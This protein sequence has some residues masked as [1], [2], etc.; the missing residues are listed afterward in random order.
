MDTDN[1][2]VQS[3]LE[4]IRRDNHSWVNGDSSGYE[5]GDESSSIMGAFGGSA[6]GASAATPGQRRAVT[7]FIEGSGTVEL[8]NCGVSDDVVWLA[9][10]ERNTVRF[11]KVDGPRRWD[12]R[13]TEVFRRDGAE[14]VRA[15]RHADPLVDRHPLTDVLALLA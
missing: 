2:I 5:F 10:I 13:V 11:D 8:V 15:H 12:L 14:W 7:Q 4:R 6:V 3:L 9:V 1:A